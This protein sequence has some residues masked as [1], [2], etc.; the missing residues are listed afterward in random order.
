MGVIIFNGGESMDDIE[1]FD[2][3]IDELKDEEFDILELN[4]EKF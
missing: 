3:F 1:F 4:A 2:S